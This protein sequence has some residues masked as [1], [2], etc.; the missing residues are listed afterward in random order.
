MARHVLF[1]I[2]PVGCDGCT[3]D[4]L[5]LDHSSVKGVRAISTPNIYPSVGALSPI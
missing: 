2:W 4:V 1:V 3:K 5:L